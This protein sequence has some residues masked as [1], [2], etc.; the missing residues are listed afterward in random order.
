MAQDIQQP[1]QQPDDPGAE[2]RKLAEQY[3][4]G[5][6]ADT[7][8][9]TA[10]PGDE[11]AALAK[12]YSTP[13]GPTAPL[14]LT[15][16]KAPSMAPRDVTEMPASNK[17]FLTAKSI[18]DAEPIADVQRGRLAEEMKPKPPAPVRIAE[19][20][21]NMAAHPID[22][23]VGIVTAPFEASAHLGMFASQELRKKQ[24]TWKGDDV[25]SPRDAGFAAAQ[26]LAMG[27]TEAAMPALEGFFGKTMAK[28][29][30][31]AV[32][33]GEA[34][35]TVMARMVAARA[36]THTAIGAGVG[37]LWTPDDPAVGAFIGGLFGGVHAIS[38]KAH[39]TI[40]RPDIDASTPADRLLPDHTQA[41]AT[42]TGHI[43]R[44][45]VSLA[46]ESESPFSVEMNS[47]GEALAQ[48]AEQYGTKKPATEPAPAPIPAAEPAPVAGE[49]D[50]KLLERIRDTRARAQ[51]G[52][53]TMGALEGDAHN[54]NALLDRIRKTRADALAGEDGELLKS[55]RS[56]RQAALESEAH[57]DDSLLGKIRA[58][59]ANALEGEGDA[60]L[61]KSIRETRA[62]ALQGEEDANLLQKIRA[63]RGTADAG[64]PD[65]SM[66]T[67][68]NALKN[69]QEAQTLLERMKTE[70]ERRSLERAANTDALTGL[71]NARAYATALPRAEADPN[72]RVLRFDMNG[73]K[74][75]ND[76]HGH[77]FGDKILQKA[78]E[79]IR[80]N[81]KG[82]PNFRV[83]GDEFATFVPADKADAIKAAIEDDFGVRDF[84]GDHGSTRVSI[85]GGHGQTNLEADQAAKVAKEAAKSKQGI[86][87]RD[88]GSVYDAP[89]HDLDIEPERFQFKGNTNEHGVTKALEGVKF[90]PDLAGVVTVWRDPADNRLKVINGHH[91]VDLA[92]RS[93]VDKMAVREI[94]APDAATA[95][96]RGALINMAEDKGTPVDVAK[97]IRD[98]GL[99]IEDIRNEG[100]N[101]KGQ[102]AKKGLALSK[103]HPTLFQQVATGQFPM[104]RGVVIGESGLE[105]EQQL[106][107]KQM[108]DQ[109]ETSG[110]RMS[111]ETLAEMIRFVRD[112]GTADI[113]QDSLFG[114]E[115]LTHSLAP[116]K[117]ELS[118]WVKDK[119][120]K[121]RR[122]FN[123]IAKSERASRIESAGVGN[124]ETERAKGIA[125]GAAQAEEVYNRLS[126]MKGPV[127][128]A[129]TA[130]ARELANGGDRNAIRSKLYDAIAGAVTEHVQS[131][132]G[133]KEGRASGLPEGRQGSEAAESR[134]GSAAESGPPDPDQIGFVAERSPGYGAV[135]ERRFRQ[136]KDQL[137]LFSYNGKET[138]LKDLP[139]EA[140]VSMRKGQRSVVRRLIEKIK[141]SDLPSAG[142]RRRGIAQAA[143]MGVVDPVG[144][145][146]KSPVQ[147]AHIMTMFRHPSMELF[148]A[149]IKD[150]EGKIVAHEIRTSGE[151]NWAAIPDG[152]PDAIA[153]LAKE[154]GGVTVTFGHN[155]PS[156]DPTPSGDDIAAT[157]ALS[158]ALEERGLK[159]DGHVVINHDKAYWLRFEEKKEI[160]G[161][162]YGSDPYRD[163]AIAVN[164]PILES[165]RQNVPWK[166]GIEAERPKIGNPF[167]A[168]HYLAHVTAPD[169]ATIAYLDAQH[170]IVAVRPYM[171]K[172]L[173]TMDQWLLEHIKAHAAKDVM[174][175]VP[176]SAAREIALKVS[177]G[178]L[179]RVEKP[180]NWGY[181]VLD[182]MGVEHDAHGIPG[183]TVS[184]AEKGI[185]NYGQYPDPLGAEARTVRLRPGESAV[186][187]IARAKGDASRRGLHPPDEAGGIRE[188][189]RVGEDLF[190]NPDE[191]EP[192]Q[193]SL[194]SSQAGSPQK[195]SD[196]ERAARAELT[197]LREKAELLER[198][199]AKASMQSAAERIRVA[200]RISELE[201]LLNRDKAISAD[202]LATRARGET[203]PGD[204]FG[205][206][207]GEPAPT[208]RKPINEYIGDMRKKIE[209]KRAPIR[210]AV[211]DGKR[212]TEFETGPESVEVISREPRD[213][214]KWRVT[215]FTPDGP[216]GHQEYSK[217]EDAIAQVAGAAGEPKPVKGR[218]QQW[219]TGER[220]QTRRIAENSPQYGTLYHGTRQTGLESLQPSKSGEFGPG[221]YLADNEDSARAWGHRAG[222][223]SPQGGEVHVLPVSADLT[224]PFHVTKQRW[225]QM[226]ERRTPRQVQ[227]DLMRK[228]H[229]GI[230]ATGINGVD[231]QIVVF[232]PSKVRINRVSEQSPRYGGKPATKDEVTQWAEQTRQSLG[233]RHFNVYVTSGNALELSD[234]EVPN[235]ARKQGVG[236]KALEALTQFADEHG[237]RIVLTPALKDPRHG[238]T[239]RARLIRFYKRFGFVENKGRRKDFTTMQGMYR[240]PQTPKSARQKFGIDSAR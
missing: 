189:H 109:R 205:G 74:G 166:T 177:R 10:E 33:K 188:T 217:L 46:A 53:A 161:S 114:T 216:V 41:P 140:D 126:T 139:K 16:P 180:E 222:A 238:T 80:R 207:I 175:M 143:K 134:F 168:A 2:L 56:T 43:E 142:E 60:E 153:Q 230:V 233:L 211:G 117:A 88:V 162:S 108:L 47:P 124:I 62:N 59:R 34:P 155:H 40:A 186:S 132:G 81:T 84:V 22:T 221:V 89:L 163:Q 25:V 172:A 78:A 72:V 19:A 5:A 129:L 20:V 115:Q 167:D 18:V 13:A 61:L 136:S 237:Q 50:A 149:Y 93:G 144:L 69:T 120:G 39:V 198:P 15:G 97:F 171:M 8:T 170:R 194:F 146:M 92:R 135:W 63:T 82:M 185:I 231:K 49:G 195:L 236:T 23:A 234:I 208:T 3:R 196:A 225:I 96:A 35:Q 38:Q 191:S 239:S 107:L 44:E 133:T 28:G 154:N 77:P 85:S 215:H 36:A 26:L 145:S 57:A 52:E 64:T 204:L 51:Q 17:D 6:A 86:K 218:V 174:L 116:E 187:Q 232:N 45:P 95:R 169:A 157:R 192:K 184:Y 127:S 240:E 79:T 119:L 21:G 110:K 206:K 123:F 130:A 11:L 65:A 121:D 209:A 75:V 48:L 111:N 29:V 213:P 131:L 122:L 90:N 30:V 173:E 94:D 100:V 235:N 200:R 226:T 31:E 190:G 176:S 54:D 104:E 201:R 55:I 103:L 42:A 83:G 106:A 67:A 113:S 197:K 165:R 24:G 112:A 202:E 152:W 98:T 148:H 1:G 141:S 199:S 179:G 220:W 7:A 68:R 101:P 27:A 14:S 223:S 66:E 99:T 91:R 32:Q 87:G 178:N 193:G 210:A 183:K 164:I 156:G 12:Q 159:V 151:L 181:P 229:D 73:F 160:D 4:G 128:D 227:A 214:S 76:A 150:A 158:E 228:G 125:T 37:A 137:D 118:A 182:V 203:D 70:H 71:G 212:P 224:N 147:A 138:R 58:T 9:A 219:M 102:L 105:P